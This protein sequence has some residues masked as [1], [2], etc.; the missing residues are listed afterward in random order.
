MP[1]A[2]WIFSL[3]AREGITHLFDY[4]FTV[5]VTAI[6]LWTLAFVGLSG[7]LNVVRKL[8]WSDPVIL[9]TDF[10]KGIKSSGKQMA[11]IGLMWGVAYAIV[12]YAIDWLGFY[13]KVF[14]NSYSVVFGIFVCL[15][16]LLTV[17]GLTVYMCCMASMYNVS[18]SQLFVGAF[19]LYF[20][21]FFL[22]TGVILLSISPILILL[23]LGLA[24]TTLIAYLLSLVLL[25]GIIIIP[26]FLVCNHT[27]D[28][29]INKKDY[30]SYYGRGLSYG[31]YAERSIDLHNETSSY[32][33]TE[34][35]EIYDSEEI[36]TN[37]ERVNDDEN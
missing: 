37:F 28:R 24:I 18:M 14:D 36:E 11:L 4:W 9:R 17:I 1:Y 26:I 6:P 22:G 2:D 25:I 27:F 10:M 31:V 21:D 29:V 35:Q 12:R 33:Y 7:G 8:A 5:H 23:M 15:F 20:A 32:D 34:N 16:L 19:K 3:D 30:P 13:Y